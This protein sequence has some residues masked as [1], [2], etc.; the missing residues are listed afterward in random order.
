MLLIMQRIGWYDVLTNVK[1]VCRHWYVLSKNPSIWRVIEL[2]RDV[3]TKLR[4]KMDIPTY[5]EYC[6]K[7]RFSEKRMETFQYESKVLKMVNKVLEKMVMHVIDL[8]RGQLHDLCI[9][10]LGS[11]NLFKYIYQRSRQLRR[12]RLENCFVCCYNYESH[13]YDGDITLKGMFQML[14]NLPLL[15]ELELPYTKIS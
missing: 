9:V 10:G 7:V 2:R 5:Q 6:S 15:E 4:E 13:D 8:S 14:R 12:L 1:K 11:D 3:A